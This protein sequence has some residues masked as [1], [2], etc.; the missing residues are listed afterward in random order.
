VNHLKAPLP[1]PEQI[2]S[3]LNSYRGQRANKFIIYFQNFSNTYDTLENLKQKYDSALIDSR[4]VGLQIAT[5]P[6]CINEDIAKEDK[7]WLTYVTY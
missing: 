3:F 2:T 6:D 5:R 1:I 4:I 7:Q